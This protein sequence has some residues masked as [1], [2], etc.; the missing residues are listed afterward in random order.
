M[1]PFRAVHVCTPTGSQLLLVV[2]LEVAAAPEIESVNTTLSLDG[3]YRIPLVV[4]AA[5]VEVLLLAL[6][7]LLL[8]LA[9]GPPPTVL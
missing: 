1:R 3:N 6:L 9:V 5:V 2:L 8:L 7:L 4:A